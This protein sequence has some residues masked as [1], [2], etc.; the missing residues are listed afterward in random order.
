[1]L[2]DVPAALEGTVDS[3]RLPRKL[4]AI[5]YADVAG[6]SR[7]T[8]EDEDGT[9]RRLSTYLDL[10]AE[11]VQFG[12]GTVVHY[13]GDAVL[14]QFPTAS[15]ALACAVHVQQSLSHENTELPADKK[16][17]FRIGVNLGE[18]IVDRDDI[19]GDGVNVAARLESLAEVAGICISESVHSAVGNKLPIDYEFM[20]EQSVKNI[21]KPVRAY[22][23]RLRDGAK[24]PRLVSHSE[25]KISRKTASIVAG[26]IV[27]L[28]F[29]GGLLIW[30]GAW[31]TTEVPEPMDSAFL[32]LPEKPSIAVLP[33]TT[34]SGMQDQ[35]YLADGVTED[36][37]TNLS[38]FEGLFVISRTS[39][40]V[41]KD[42]SM[43]SQE[44][45][46]EL[47]VRY[48]LEGSVQRNEDQLRVTAQLIE[49]GS[50]KHLWAERY[51]RGVEDIFAIQDEITG[52][53]ATTLGETLWQARAR[54]VARKP[55]SSFEAYD[56]RL[57]GLD[58]LHRLTK[59][60]NIRAREFYEKALKLDPEFASAYVGLGWTYFLDFRTKW[61]QVGPE[62]LDKAL[63]SA[64]KAAKLDPNYAQ[65]YRLISR[66]YQ[67]KRRYQEALAMMNRALELNPN[68][69]DIL[70]G[71]G[72]LLIHTGQTEEGIEMAAK[73]IRRNP[74]H[75][76]WY[77]TI[78]AI[79][80]F[81]DGRHAEAL[82]Y[83]NRI[84]SPKMW[85]HRLLA[86][87]YA[88]LGEIDKAKE[89]IAAILAIN[90]KSTL[91][92]IEPSLAFKNRADIDRYLNGLRK[93]G[94]PE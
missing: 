27:A 30:S 62:A 8:G 50:G 18:V 13:A 53:I 29:T 89:H 11:S 61:V 57:R 12:N 83:M 72:S 59:E 1:M 21:E 44:I 68:H 63:Y 52:A 32:P 55:A 15:E 87:T 49:A 84:D 19:Y 46:R 47:G 58:Y 20:G 24:L 26:M 69:G 37:I 92:S 42:K 38:R 80:H 94:M 88:E 93:A 43:K 91:A 6:Y 40:T 48:L 82:R 75:P 54:E 31:K 45:G 28:V 33:F 4:V 10:V 36:V 17:Q 74:H 16:I 3:D 67:Y 86:A 9:H 85:D 78:I 7:L 35:E 5:V 90:P 23:A 81:M 76:D 22:H 25:P 34:I 65:A 41:Y 39:S 70:A 79:G 60:D 56:F 64:Q 14:A 71:Y 66:I 73:A 51:D 77:G 2:S